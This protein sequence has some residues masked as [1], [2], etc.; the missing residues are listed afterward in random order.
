MIIQLT[1]DSVEAKLEELQ[2]ETDEA[3]RKVD[4]EVSRWAHYKDDPENLAQILANVNY[5]AIELGKL[6]ATYEKLQLW[7]TKRYDIEKGMAAVRGIRSGKSAT[8]AEATKYADPNIHR[9][10]D[11]MAEAVSRYRLVQNQRATARDSAEGIRS[12]IGQLRNEIRSSQ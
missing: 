6:Y 3:I 4:I 11:I 7:A 9:A 2:P 5:Y 8:H 10:L 12:R 1:W